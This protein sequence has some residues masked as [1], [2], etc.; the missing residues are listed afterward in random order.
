MVTQTTTTCTL[1]GLPTLHPITDQQ[2]G[3]FCCPACREVA[4]LLQ[5]SSTP[6][7][8]TEAAAQG[9]APEAAEN[10]TLSLS[11]MWCSSCAWLIGEQLKRSPGVQSA[12]VSF[13]QQ[14]A[15]L[16]FDL[17]KTN[18]KRLKRR[19]RQLG[20][21]ANLPDEKPHDE[22]D[23]FLTRLLIGGVLAMHVMLISIM[24]YIREGFGMASP[25]TQWLADF[26]QVMLLLAS[27]PLV[28]ILGLPILRAGLISLLRGRPNTHTLIAIGA[29]AAFG[30]SLRNHF[31]GSGPVYFDTASMLLFLV[32]IGRWLEMQA[33]KASGEAVERLW[34][35]IPPEAVW[36]TS[37]GEKIVPVD[38]LPPGARVRVKPGERFPVDGL[39]AIGEGDVDTSL[40]T[41][42]PT[43]VT[44]YPGDAALA[45]TVCLDGSFEVIT[46]AVGAETHA[47]QIGRLLHQALWQRAP[48]ERLADR[49]AAWMVPA[50]IALAGGA[51]YFWTTRLG[52]ET[53]LLHAL[54][55]LL[56]ACPC[57]L[58]LA[59]PLTLWLSLGRAAE[60]GVILRSTAVLE[61]LGR[62]KQVF[63]DKT[64]TLSQLPMR[65]QAIKTT[66]HPIDAAHPNEPEQTTEFL[67]SVA[68]LEALSEHPLGQAIVAEAQ[69]RELPLPT[70]TD[71]H[72]LPGQGVTAQLNGQQLWV[73][74]QRLMT[75]Q[76]LHTAP[77]LAQ[78]AREWQSQGL[79]VV[80]AGWDGEVRGLLGLGET[81]RSEAIEVVRQLRNDGLLVAVL[82]G[83]D[84]SAGERWQDALGVPVHA[85]LL[86]DE[87]MS[88]LQNAGEGVAMVGDGIND[89][90]ALAAASVG[91]A[92]SQG[93]DVARAA[94]EAVLVQDDLRAV[95]WLLGL[96]Q[97]AMRRVH[98]NLAWAFVYNLIGLAFALTG[99]LQPVLAALAMVTSSLIV[100]LNALR[101][102]RFPTLHHSKK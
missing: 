34:K 63:F 100:T 86:P 74:S 25:D 15:H 89:G 6:A 59:T 95:P 5:D 53:G 70:P 18:P 99:H 3:V 10:V 97:E 65:V 13:I 75:A 84:A 32:T 17:Q 101:L 26:F 71:F 94:A 77:E 51:F 35:Q 80:Y 85:G 16:T 43:P 55:V 49:L 57:A 78:T 12:D 93:T 8:A 46:T 58:G 4:H 2:G 45:G 44:H 23:A 27:G 37:E 54:S 30:L 88:H 67:Q 39:I 83:D 48:V 90:P 24:L 68:A 61:K 33:H 47:G 102:R 64:G 96:S 72:A 62:V 98:Q 21:R 38:K 82:T 92:L 56:I 50:A 69:Q 73:G 60:S 36:L 42:E 14:E 41:G 87:K 91:I 11:G 22:E 1:C 81:I 19:V 66:P 40:L 79:S 52:L 31:A 20:Y 7:P 28:L 29:F 9:T 76:T